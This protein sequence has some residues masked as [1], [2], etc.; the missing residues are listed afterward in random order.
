MAPAVNC[1]SWN[2]VSLQPPQP[3]YPDIELPLP[4]EL[5][6]MEPQ[7]F[8]QWRTQAKRLLLNTWQKMWRYKGLGEEEEDQLV[9][10]YRKMRDAIFGVRD[11]SCN[12]SGKKEWDLTIDWAASIE[13]SVDE[14]YRLNLVIPSVVT[15]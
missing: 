2:P 15:Q 9:A 6:A 8:N 11:Y 5:E 3:F 13:A 7:Q 4:A 12:F 1:G 14:K 10:L